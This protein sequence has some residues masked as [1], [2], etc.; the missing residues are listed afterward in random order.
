VAVERI[1]AKARRLL[2]GV[3]GYKAQCWP[4]RCGRHMG[5][6]PGTCPGPGPYASDL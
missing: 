4:R 2:R 3:D 6:D 1:V 5:L